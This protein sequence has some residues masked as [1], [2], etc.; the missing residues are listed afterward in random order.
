MCM[1]AAAVITN[2]TAE[3]S[4]SQGVATISWIPLTG[5]EAENV[6]LYKIVY[7]SAGMRETPTTVYADASA[8]SVTI[9]NLLTDTVYLFQVSAVA[10]IDNDTIEGD[11]SPLDHSAFLVV[12]ATP[13]PRTSLT[14][15]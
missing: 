10:R 15:C 5:V 8:S 2:M 3:Y 12:E 1:H 9:D 14:L 7:S 6:V 13:A 11:Q 4:A